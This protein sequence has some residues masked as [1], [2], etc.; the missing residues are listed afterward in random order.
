MNQSSPNTDSGLD[1][2][3]GTESKLLLRAL[4]GEAC[5]RPPIWLMRQAG[6]YLP[7]YRATRKKAP[8]FLDF[9]YTP[10]LAVEVT[11]QPIRRFGFDAAI[12]FSDI[13]V[14]PHALGQKVWFEE[15]RGPRL[16]PV[17]GPGELVRL[18]MCS[19]DEN[20]APVYE[21]V[22]GIRS[23]L[24]P[25]TALIGF[26][27][28]PWTVASYMVEGGGT[29][30]FAKVKTWAYGDPEGFQ[31]LIELLVDA[32]TQYLES[33]IAAGVEVLQLFDSWAGALTANGMRQWCLDPNA[34]IIRRIKANHPHIPIILFP[35]GAGLMY[36][37]IAAESG[38]DA[39]AVDSTVPPAWVRDEL[40]SQVA[41][42]GNLDPILLV[43]GGEVLRRSAT[44]ILETLA[45]GPFVFNLGSGIVPEADPEHVGELVE[46]VQGWSAR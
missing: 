33:Q 16:D 34:E 17:A 10:E 14:V 27:G 42:Q 37:D 45:G 8:S 28:A 44:E 2:V 23:E 7:E 12:L 9:C 36:R 22:R 38:A 20:L 5:A 1:M 18:S 41:V 29:R 6:R 11:L 30:E 13:M 19:L 40:Q 43:A 3:T 35:R 26:A 39:V 46:L 24:G 32:T 15:G 21:T 4:R 25:E 31:K